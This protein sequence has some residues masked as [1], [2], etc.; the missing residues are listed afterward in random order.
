M[1]DNLV[2]QYL[3][4]FVYNS[5]VTIFISSIISDYQK[6]LIILQYAIVTVSSINDKNQLSKFFKP[7]V[8]RHKQSLIHSVRRCRLWNMCCVCISC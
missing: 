8:Q 6:Q 4:T 2:L 1:R 3:N 5:L 7:N